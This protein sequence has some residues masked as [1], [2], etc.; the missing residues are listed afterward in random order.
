MISN[1]TMHSINKPV[2]THGIFRIR[3]STLSFLTTLIFST[4][5]SSDRMMVSGRHSPLIH[6]ES[7][8]LSMLTLR[9]SLCSFRVS[10]K[11]PRKI[12]VSAFTGSVIMVSVTRTVSFDSNSGCDLT[13]RSSLLWG[14]HEV[15]RITGNKKIVIITI[16]FI[17]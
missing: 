6:R 14:E 13:S 4:G 2:T 9:F 16:F 1:N 17:F 8:I 10:V 11:S 15:M 12:A 3:R 5:N 7:A